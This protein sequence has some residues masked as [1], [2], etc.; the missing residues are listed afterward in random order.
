MSDRAIDLDDVSGMPTAAEIF[1]PRPVPMLWPSS[2]DVL[3]LA[4]ELLPTIADDLTA[5][6]VEHLALAL[7]DRGQ[8]LRAVRAVLSAALT[9]SN[10]QHA[11]IIRLKRR[12][13]DLLDARQRERPAAA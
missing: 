1:G 10:T 8:E 5:D 13:A 11:E 7:V 12:L 2:R 6:L 3:A 4:I 9:L